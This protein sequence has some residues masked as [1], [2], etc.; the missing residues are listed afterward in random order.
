MLPAGNRLARF[1]SR[2]PIYREGQPV[3]LLV[4]LNTDTPPVPK[5][6]AA[7]VRLLRDDMQVAVV[8]LKANAAQP[9]L[10]E[11]TISSLPS[12]TY[13]IEVELPHLK[14]KLAGKDA[15]FTVALAPQREFRDLSAD[16]E[17]L[18]ELA[19]K[20]GG[21]LF[22]PEN[23]EQL[24]DLFARQITI[25]EHRAEHKLWQDAPL[26]WWVLALLVLLVT[27]EWSV[28]KMAGLP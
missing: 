27:V 20:T 12:G 21:K 14:E 15:E 6:G 9:R 5:D 19:S 11:G 24:V 10:L 4:R 25:R 13:R 18:G 17:L 23:V 16:W 7:Q 22:T 1:G 2:D 28:R 3:E 8:E 26:V